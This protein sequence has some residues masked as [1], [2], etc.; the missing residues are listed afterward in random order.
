MKKINYERD[1]GPL[2]GSDFLINFIVHFDISQF[3][4]KVK[5]SAPWSKIFKRFSFDDFL[6]DPFKVQ[7]SLK[8]S[9]QWIE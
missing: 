2:K 3:I 9:S 6:K 8:S 5:S 4:W 7:T 1:R